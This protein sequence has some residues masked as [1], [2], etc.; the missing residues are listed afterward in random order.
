MKKKYHTR[1]CRAAKKAKNVREVSETEAETMDL[2]LCAY[3]AGEHT[4]DNY[5]QSYQEA[6]KAEAKRLQAG[7]D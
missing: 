7:G 3:C 5:T 1:M 6:L 2:E 4:T